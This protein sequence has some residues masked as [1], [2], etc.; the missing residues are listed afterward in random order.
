MTT[1][2]PIRLAQTQPSAPRL[3]RLNDLFVAAATWMQSPF[4]LAVRL[5]WG[6]QFLFTG[7]GKLH[8]LAKVTDYFAS[9][10]IPWPALNAPMIATLECLGGLLLILGLAARPVAL[11]LAGNML[12]AFLTAE[13]EA[14]AAIFSDP[15]KF[16]AAAPYTF[17]FASVLITLFGPGTLALDHLLARLRRTGRGGA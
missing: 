7:W 1:M 13:R 2:D 10:G 16:Y 5:Y 9:L 12:V 4:L 8:N 17:L 15:D 3:A 6:W 14:L 11:L